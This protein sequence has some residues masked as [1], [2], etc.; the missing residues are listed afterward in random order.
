MIFVDSHVH[1]YDCFD[2]D[3]LLDAALNN[4][5]KAAKQYNSTGYPSTYVLLLTEGKNEHWF[6][7][8]LATLESTNQGNGNISKNWRVVKKEASDSLMVFRNDS[9]ETA[10]YLVAGRQVVTKE[11]IEV[12]A[13]YTQQVIRDGRSLAETVD[14]IMKANAIVVLPWGVGKWFGARG[15]IIQSLLSAQ[16]RVKVYLGDNG[17]RPG[18]WPR[19]TLF[20][21]VE[22]KGVAVLPGT[23][24]LPLKSETCRAGSFGFYL[25]DSLSQEEDPIKHLKNVLLSQST[26][27]S[28]FGHLQKNSLFLFNQLRLRLS[29]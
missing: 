21:L 15:K 17:G 4:F 11:R 3:L 2:V 14:I 1:I 16:S 10:I 9:L 23:D 5:Q 6:K 20:R 24:A 19:P 26:P 13:L 28:P 7:R 12:L 27:M 8:S 25:D 29:S 18:L 22:K